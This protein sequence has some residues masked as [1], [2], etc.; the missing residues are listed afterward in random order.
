[1]EN[2]NLIQNALTF[3]YFRNSKR[4]P[5]FRIASSKFMILYRHNPKLTQE[6]CQSWICKISVLLYVSQRLS[7]FWICS[8]RTRFA[9]YLKDC[10]TS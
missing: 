9:Q 7:H 8:A 2:D 6:C 3:P 10:D 5:T 4:T 1:M